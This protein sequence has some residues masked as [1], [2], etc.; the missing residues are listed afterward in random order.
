MNNRV[1]AATAGGIGLAAV[2]VTVALA[3]A[4]KS[5]APV[6]ATLARPARVLETSCL[7]QAEDIEPSALT[8]PTVI[9]YGEPP[10]RGVAEFQKPD[11]H[12]AHQP[13]V[14]LP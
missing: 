9:I 12:A 13:L 2:I 7:R 14:A 5:P 1:V 6:A 11:K 10:R 3:H 4:M 8:V